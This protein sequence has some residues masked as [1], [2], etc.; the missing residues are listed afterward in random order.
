MPTIATLFEKSPSRGVYVRRSL[1]HWGELLEEWCLVHERYC[2]LVPGD[3][4]YWNG[5]RPNVAALAAAAWRCGWAALE[6]FAQPKI[7]NRSGFAGRAD[8]Y[9]L[10]PRSEDYVEAK[11]DWFSVS[12]KRSNTVRLLRTFRAALADAHNVHLKPG[13]HRRVGVAF[14]SPY[15]REE[16]LGPASGG[17]TSVFGELTKEN[18]DAAAWCFPM[19]AQFLKWKDRSAIHYHP[20]VVLLATTAA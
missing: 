6:E 14:G 2:R 15:T 5:E 10:S 12:S 13:K 18:F 11:F 3:A 1:R 17:L 16:R 9:L 20:G 4:I 8:L 19:A 7:A